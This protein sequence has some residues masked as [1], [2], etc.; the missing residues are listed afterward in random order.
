MTGKFLNLE[1]KRQS[2][3]CICQADLRYALALIGQELPDL[4]G[5]L[6]PE[7]AG[8]LGSETS[9]RSCCLLSFWS[10]VDICKEAN[11]V[12]LRGSI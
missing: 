5:S 6:P 1:S 11:N 12:Q 10:T 7:P 4:P 2:L 8:A 3:T 9:L